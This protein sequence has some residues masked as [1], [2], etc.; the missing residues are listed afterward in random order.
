LAFK[1]LNQSEPCNGDP[2]LCHLKFDQ[3]TWAGAH[4]ADA[5][6]LRVKNIPSECLTDNHEHYVKRELQ[7]GLR[8]FDI[9]TCLR[10]EGKKPKIEIC[11]G[12]AMGTWLGPELKNMK[13]FLDENKRE[14]AVLAFTNAEQNGGE[15]QKYVMMETL[16][17]TVREAFG[18]L[19]WI[20]ELDKGVPPNGWP[21]LKEL[22]DTNKRVAVL[23]GKRMYMQ[24]Y[25]KD[26][27]EPGFRDQHIWFEKTWTMT[28]TEA[29]SHLK[30]DQLKDQLEHFCDDPTD[31]KKF[32]KKQPL[33]MA[34]VYLTIDPIGRKSLSFCNKDMAGDVNPVILEDHKITGQPL[35]TMQANCW[36]K[37]KQVSII[38]ADYAEYFPEHLDTIARALNTRN[39]A[40]YGWIGGKITHSSKEKVKSLLAKLGGLSDDKR[41][42]VDKTEKATAVTSRRLAA[43]EV[44]HFSILAPED[45]L[46]HSSN[47][48]VL[49]KMKK[50]AKSEK[51]VDSIIAVCRDPGIPETTTRDLPLADE[52]DEG[53]MLTFKCKAELVVH[54]DLERTCGPDGIFTGIQ[55]Q[56]LEWWTKAWRLWPW[57]AKALIITLPVLCVLCCCAGIIFLL[58][59]RCGKG[60]NYEKIDETGAGPEAA[61]G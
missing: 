56:C 30:P 31:D 6:H 51:D 48:E 21:T 1:K 25:K 13:A 34:D 47:S 15:D 16:T 33:I 53:T 29:Y 50:A 24:I 10:Y 39:F 17:D 35:L 57:W 42:T 54:G 36:K 3:V 2:A 9:D 27:K 19:L 22:V 12:I 60:K 40:R 18:E 52:F 46:D 59:K 26:K 11:H 38:S 23:W 55:P 8:F 28:Y 5:I 49:Q 44:V 58:V 7:D 37:G 20:P 43:A 61:E 14:V 32:S 45:A 4:N 41:I